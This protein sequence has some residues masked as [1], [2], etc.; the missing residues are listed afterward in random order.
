ML[1][2]TDNEKAKCLWNTYTF[3]KAQQIL[4]PSLAFTAIMWLLKHYIF[5]EISMP[6]FLTI[7]AI[8]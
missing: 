6:N 1:E 8:F 7:K 5:H 2:K 4:E 3:S